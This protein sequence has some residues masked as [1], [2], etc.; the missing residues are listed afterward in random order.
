[1]SVLRACFNVGLRVVGS[2]YLVF[3][4]CFLVLSCK[5]WWILAGARKLVF[6]FCIRDGVFGFSNHA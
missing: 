4:T 2:Q 5:V 6:G 1:V 3:Y